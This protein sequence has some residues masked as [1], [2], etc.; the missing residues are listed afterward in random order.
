MT[1]IYDHLYGS[2]G[3]EFYQIEQYIVFNA[4]LQVIFIYI[5]ATQLIVA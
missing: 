3:G 4:N 2:V 5:P 1:L